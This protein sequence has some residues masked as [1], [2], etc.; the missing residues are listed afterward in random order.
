VWGDRALEDGPVVLTVGV[1]LIAAL[2][3]DTGTHGGHEFGILW[4]CGA[5][6][7]GMVGFYVGSCVDAG[8]HVG[9]VAGPRV[10]GFEAPHHGIAERGSLVLQVHCSLHD[11]VLKELVQWDK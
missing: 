3:V 9:G 6:D 1:G 8:I 4:P 5:G 7:E 11:V 2:L 10:D